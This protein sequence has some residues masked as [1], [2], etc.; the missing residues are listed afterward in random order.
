MS[1]L[2]LLLFNYGGSSNVVFYW[3]TALGSKKPRHDEFEKY[4]QITV[5]SCI[6]VSQVLYQ[7]QSSN[8]VLT[9]SIDLFCILHFSKSNQSVLLSWFH[10]VRGQKN[11]NSQYP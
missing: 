10:T 6:R 7:G 8:V 5:Y 11:V 9:I 4:K 1:D 3:H 2:Y